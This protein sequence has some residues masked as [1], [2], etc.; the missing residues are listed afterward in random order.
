M[1][2]GSRRRVVSVA[3]VVAVI[4]VTAAVSVPAAARQSSRLTTPVVGGIRLVPR[5]PDVESGCRHAARVLRFSVLCPVLLPARWSTFGSVCPV[6]SC[7]GEFS[8]TGYFPGPRS[9]V[10]DRP[11]SGHFNIWALPTGNRNAAGFGCPVFAAPVMSR[12]QV[13]GAR[14]SRVLRDRHSTRDTCS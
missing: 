7:R 1:M 6:A 8:I 3:A 5:P 12:L 9:Y 13:I 11:R 4:A 2:T 10:G 14:G